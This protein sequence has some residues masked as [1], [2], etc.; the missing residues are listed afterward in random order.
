M[1]AGRSYFVETGTESELAK[2][3]K[4]SRDHYSSLLSRML[5]VE[6][7]KSLQDLP[8]DGRRAAIHIKPKSTGGN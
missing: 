6:Q 2:H 3:K 4:N 1:K 7:R 5:T 8:D